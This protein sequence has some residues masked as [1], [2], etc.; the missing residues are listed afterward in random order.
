MPTQGIREVTGRAKLELVISLDLL[1]LLK[2]VGR[3][4][5]TAIEAEFTVMNIVGSMAIVA[6]APHPELNV[7]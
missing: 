6:P 5:P 3:M 1:Y 7:Q 4:A 2:G